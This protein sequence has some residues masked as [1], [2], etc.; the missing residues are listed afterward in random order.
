MMLQKGNI[1]KGEV[2]GEVA[3]GQGGIR[4]DGGQGGGGGEE[5]CLDDVL[6]LPQPMKRMALKC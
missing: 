5:E 6:V 3:D 1:Q 2:V 4:G